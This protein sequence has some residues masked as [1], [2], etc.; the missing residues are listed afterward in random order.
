MRRSAEILAIS[1]GFVATAQAEDRTVAFEYRREAGAEGCP[2]EA[3]MKALVAAALGYDPF[4]TDA[5]RSIG[6]TIKKRAGVFEARIVAQEG[7]RTLSDRGCAELARA[8]ALAISVA[9]DPLSF[10]RTTTSTIAP[11]PPPPPAPPPPAP[12]ASPPPP[13][14]PPIEEGTSIEL[15]FG[16]GVLAAIETVPNHATGGLWIEARAGWPHFTLGVEGRVDLPRSLEL[17]D[18]SRV[19]A[20]LAAAFLVPC[21]RHDWF[22]ACA[23]G[24][25]GAVFASGEG[26]AGETDTTSAYA[27]AGVRAAAVVAILEQLDLVFRAEVAATLARTTLVVGDEEVWTSPPFSGAVGAGIAWR[28]L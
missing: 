1:L 26:L 3:S 22:S 6:L 21:F 12:I 15:A 13:P 24:G 4:R 16:G 10:R 7:E 5:P 23:V 17:G 19:R 27:S 18:R 2:D 25:A 20:L 28:F 9:I 8:T 11:P 14:P